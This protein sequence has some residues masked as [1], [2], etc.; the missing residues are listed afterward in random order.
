MASDRITI[1]PRNNIEHVSQQVILLSREPNQSR[2]RL[3][4]TKLRSYRCGW[5][6][7]VSSCCIDLIYSD[8]QP[9]QRVNYN[10]LLF[11]FFFFSFSFIPYDVGAVTPS[12]LQWASYCEILLHPRLRKPQIP[13]CPYP[14]LSHLASASM[15]IGRLW[16]C[17]AT[18]LAIMCHILQ[19]GMTPILSYK[20]NQAQLCCTSP[21]IHLPCVCFVRRGNKLK[22]NVFSLWLCGFIGSHS[23]NNHYDIINPPIKYILHGL[24][25]EPPEKLHSSCAEAQ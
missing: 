7:H 5:I 15:S 8:L 21:N 23:V 2:S 12:S 4:H 13:T 16:H 11:F 24:I 18:D 3:I 22:K 20:D 17:T 6:L 9:R 25:C 14:V 10:P 1:S 19:G